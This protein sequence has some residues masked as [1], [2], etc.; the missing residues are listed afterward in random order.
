MG[1]NV[2]R[3]RYWG[4][5]YV[6]HSEKR[7]VDFLAIPINN[8]ISKCYYRR[9]IPMTTLSFSF[10]LT[11]NCLLP[12][13]WLAAI[14]YLYSDCLLSFRFVLTGRCKVSSLLNGFNLFSVLTGSCCYLCPD[15]QLLLSLPWLAAVVISALTGSCFLSLSWLTAVC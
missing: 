12:L 4:R 9:N 15:W 14:C 10:V 8:Q 5:T 11:G 3:G 6:R 2:G 1:L 13:S 7:L